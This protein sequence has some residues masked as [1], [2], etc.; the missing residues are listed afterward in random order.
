MGASAS[1]V[2]IAVLNHNGRR[3]LE[4]VLPSLARQ[5]LQG[6]TLN[7][8]DDASSD[9]S[10]AYLAEQWPQAN[11]IRSAQNVGIT[12]SMARAIEAADTPYVAVLNNDLELDERWLEELL[13]ALEA[14]PDA[15]AV[16]SKLLGYHDRSLIDGVGDSMARTGYPARRGQ[17][18]R[19]EGQY[20]Q[21]VEVFSVSGAAGLY[22]RAAF[23]R[24][25]TY[26]R[27]FVAYY[28][29]VDWGLRARLQGL[30]AWAV[31]AAVAYHIGSAT[32]KR[33]PGGFT[34]LI[35]RNQV[36]MVLKGFP[37]ALLLQLAPR[38]LLFQLKWL[39]FDIKEGRGRS[40]VRGLA[41][42]LPLLRSTLRKRQAIQ[43]GRRIEP[44][45]LERVIG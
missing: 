44:R 37:G 11:V 15:A 32:S 43:R 6:F 28:E 1:E 26:D 17:G 8:I 16:D 22:R 18:E 20:D 29:D 23:E 21:P 35:V 33:K 5:T 25:G 36:I 10:L 12:G 45:E 9:D 39:L 31:P 14:R 34:H 38:M 4:L 7:V 40:H 3:F 27:D 42:V 24:V 30:T 41:G 19:D 13:A 2:T